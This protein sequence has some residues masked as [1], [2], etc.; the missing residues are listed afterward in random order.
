MVVGVRVTNCPIYQPRFSTTRTYNKIDFDQMNK[1]ISED[2]RLSQVMGLNDTNLIAEIIIN[3]IRDQLNAR[4][5]SRRIQCKS[6][7]ISL[8]QET[9]VTMETRDMAWSTYCSDPSID[10]LRDYRSKK[11][12]VKNL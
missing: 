8:S 10:N 9:K 5:P 3:V 1:E 4:A 7:K 2:H 12:Q 11:N 6:N